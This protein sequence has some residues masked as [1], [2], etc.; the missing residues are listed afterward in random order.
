ML[1]EEYEITA[2]LYSRS[3]STVLLEA[4][5]TSWQYVIF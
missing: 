4:I 5:L 3:V 2:Y 1:G